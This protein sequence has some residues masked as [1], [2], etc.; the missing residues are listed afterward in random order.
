[1]TLLKRYIQIANTHPQCPRIDRLPGVPADDQIQ[2]MMTLTD[3][4]RLSATLAV[5]TQDFG[6][7]TIPLA[8]ANTTNDQTDTWQ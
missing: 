7:P 4:Q 8:L 6:I 3:N 1:M 5:K 2:I